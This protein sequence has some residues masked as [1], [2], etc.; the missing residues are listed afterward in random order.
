MEVFVRL[1]WSVWWDLVRN[2]NNSS[3]PQTKNSIAITTN[4]I[5]LEFSSY[6]GNVYTHSKSNWSALTVCIVF[7]AKSY[8]FVGSISKSVTCR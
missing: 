5:N 3:L 4:H 8:N 2:G 6:V 7:V 1:E